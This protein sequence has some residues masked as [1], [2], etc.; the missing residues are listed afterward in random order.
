M[1]YPTDPRRASFVDPTPDRRHLEERKARAL[2]EQAQA[3]KE[4][5]AATREQTKALLKLEETLRQVLKKSDSKIS[6]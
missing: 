5:A 2:E 6:V 1:T 3:Q 4:M